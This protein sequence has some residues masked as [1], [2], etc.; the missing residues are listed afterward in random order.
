[1]IGVVTENEDVDEWVI[2]IYLW[3]TTQ[4]G[5]DHLC[6]ICFDF[7]LFLLFLSL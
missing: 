2:S 3:S 4:L 7:W 1:M 6:K 5:I